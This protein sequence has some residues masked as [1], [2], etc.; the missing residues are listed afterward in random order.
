MPARASSSSGGVVAAATREEVEWLEWLDRQDVDE[1]IRSSTETKRKRASVSTRRLR[2]WSKNGSSPG[3]LAGGSGGGSG[4]GSDGGSGGLGGGGSRGGGGG[5]RGVRRGSGGG[6]GDGGDAGGD[7]EDS[8]G[9]GVGVRGGSDISR[10]VTGRSARARNAGWQSS[11]CPAPRPP[12]RLPRLQAAAGGAAAAVVAAAA[13]EAAAGGQRRLGA[14][15]VPA[16]RRSDTCTTSQHSLPDRA[17]PASRR[18]VPG[19]PGGGGRVRAQKA[20]D[21][22]A[23]RQRGRVRAPPVPRALLR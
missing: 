3:A 2:S 6:G 19:E 21:A 1:E 4:G 18:G 22:G 11:P 9:G 10:L 15:A 5:G 20:K 13:A 12:R 16:R 17:R 7:G 23:S 8:I 14:A